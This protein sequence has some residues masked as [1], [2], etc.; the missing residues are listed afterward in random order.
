MQSSKSSLSALTLGALGV[1][2]GDIGTS[3]LYAFKEVFAHS[4]VQ[5]S[6]ANVLGVLSLF[7]WAL[8]VVVSLKYVVLIMRADNH[9][10]GGLMA[11]LALAAESVKD[12]PRLRR[13]LLMLG[14]F[15]LALFFGD[16]VITPAISVLSAV[17]GL[18]I[19]TP[20]AEPYVRPISLVVL[21]LLFMVQRRGTGDIGKFFGPVTLLWFGVL[22]V[23]GVHQIV[24]N[25][26]VLQALSPLHALR[27]SFEN[28]HIAFITLGAVFLCLT[29]AE[30]LYADMGHFGKKPI[31]LA[32]FAVVMPA[33]VLNYFGQ[34]ALVLLDPSAVE[35]PFYLMVPEWALIPTVVLATAATVIASQALIT[36]A[37]SAT[38]QT[39]QMGYLPRLT[40]L[41]TSVRHT[42]QI[43]VPAV[44]WLLLVGVIA[45]VLMFGSS[46]ALAA[47]YGISVSLLMVI[48]TVLT[49]YVV[50]YGW[51]YSL[52]LCI[53]AT[54]F[55][56]VV[57]AVF[58]ASNS[59]KIMQG[60]W[61]PLVMAVVL[62]IVM[63]TWKDG[64]RLLG[65]KQREQAMDLQSFMDSVFVSP[66]V[67]V[68]GTAVFLTAEKATVPNALLHNLKH[69]KVLH[70]HN[71]FVTVVNH[72]I[73]WIGMDKRLEV[74]ALG[75]K[76][77]QVIIHYGFKNSPDVPKALEQIR[78]R[79][80]ELEVMS[81]SYFLSRDTVIPTLGGGMAPWRE[82]L[83]AQMH[84]NASGAADFLRL[85]N[86]AV[87]ELGSKIEI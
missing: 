31:R 27:F 30:A 4:H 60:G 53:G 87:V 26:V 44:N 80:C 66:P 50:R 81:T 43:Y 71:L 62:Y 61:F 41:H 49:F 6:E 38:K 42:G 22:A 67:R 45:A 64:R 10:E 84:H 28:L 74:E 51:G 37:F 29:G 11:L 20:A 40:I 65:D 56:L 82:K 48:T 9:G 72:P 19:I 70:E 39:I 12:S 83:F 57:D 23:M 59:L 34:G 21:V 32:W 14:I 63:S 85:P 68:E 73:P 5:L 15:G 77:W 75:H 17:E 33:L 24:Q 46:G 8:M 76:C 54:G 52:P 35:N 86:N 58:L 7:F 2:Y 47:A 78:G 16:G 18:A 25:P 13:A 79:G 3:P 36:G 55:F 1:V 69:N